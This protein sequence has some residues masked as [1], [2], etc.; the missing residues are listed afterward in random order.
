MGVVLAW[1]GQQALPQDQV[2]RLR[3]RFEEELAALVPDTWLRHDGGGCDWGVSALHPPVEEVLA[4]SP[5]AHEGAVTAV[6]LGI[7]VGLA[8]PGGPVR[9]A[10]RLLDGEDVHAEVVPPFG[11]LALDEPWR[12][13]LQ[14][15]WLGMSRLFAASHDGV[16]GFCNRPTLLARVLGLPVRPDLDG[17]GSYAVAG[18]FGGD[19]S[20]VRGVRLLGPGARVEGRRTD[21]RGWV[22]TTT[23]RH[24]V[25]DLVRAARG[26]SEEE[27]LALAGDGIAGAVASAV[28]LSRSPI[29][30]GLSGGKD[31]RLVAAAFVAAG[32]LPQLNTN[33]DTPAEGETAAHLVA[34]LRRNRGLDPVHHQYRAGASAGVLGLG[35]GERLRRLQLQHDFQFPSTYTVRPPGPDRLSPRARP[36][37]FTGSGGELATGYWYPAEGADARAA[38]LAHQLGHAARPDV[39]AAERARLEDVLARGSALG[40]RDEELC[41]YLYLVERVRRWYTSAYF[42]G[43]VTPFLA[44]GFVTASFA[45]PPA[46]KRARALHGALLRRWVPEWAEVPYVSI[47]TGRSTATRVWEGDGLETLEQLARRTAGELPALMDAPAV[48]S[49]LAAAATGRAS[50]AQEKTLQQLAWLAAAAETLEPARPP[51]RRRLWRL[52]GPVSEAKPVAA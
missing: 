8:D 47:S 15:D 49:A 46:A 51:A 18:C 33:V 1:F 6:S 41:D 14:Q 27:A 37:S 20:P 25:D 34:L 26:L 22:L 38:A 42:T 30:L 19:L 17:W 2:R 4:W 44:P 16:T 40:L 28:D 45:L 24:A 23:Q 7:P 31:S 50:R 48:E 29:E 10:R 35:L 21:E 52:L 3:V 32:R 13:V 43:M 5:L 9:L 12:F 11:L 36:M 39:V